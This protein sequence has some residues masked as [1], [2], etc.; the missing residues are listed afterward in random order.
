MHRLPNETRQLPQRHR[1]DLRCGVL[2]IR[3]TIDVPAKTIIAVSEIKTTATAP[4]PRIL[5]VTTG[6]VAHVAAVEDVAGMAHREVS[7]P[8]HP[9]PPLLAHLSRDAI[10]E[11]ALAVLRI[12]V[13]SQIGPNRTIADPHPADAMDVPRNNPP[14]NLGADAATV[15]ASA[16]HLGSGIPSSCRMLR[17]PRGKSSVNWNS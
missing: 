8:S 3:R 6:V 1:P 17:F 2:G 13:A 7:A 9:E 14:P 16:A 10:E 11:A 5:T 4:R 15:A 12:A